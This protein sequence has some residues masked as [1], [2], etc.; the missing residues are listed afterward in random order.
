MI[1]SL[2]E[3]FGDDTINALLH[4]LQRMFTAELINKEEEIKS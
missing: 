4:V 3:V 1:S 2:I